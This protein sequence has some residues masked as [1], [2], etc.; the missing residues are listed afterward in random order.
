MAA[1]HADLANCDTPLEAGIG[2]S[3]LSKLKQTGDDAPQF[4]G[5]AAL[6]KQRAAGVRRKLVCLVLGGDI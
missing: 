4:V 1:R 2:F 3:V 6:E 5:R